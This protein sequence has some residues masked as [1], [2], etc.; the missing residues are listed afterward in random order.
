M[1]VQVKWVESQGSGKFVIKNYLLL[2]ARVFVTPFIA[3]IVMQ[4]VDVLSWFKTC[5]TH[6]HKRSVSVCLCVYIL[7]PQKC[8]INKGLKT[9]KTFVC[10]LWIICVVAWKAHML[11]GKHKNYSARKNHFSFCLLF[12]IA[13]L[14]CVSVCIHAVFYCNVKFS[15]I[16]FVSVDTLNNRQ[17]WKQKITINAPFIQCEATK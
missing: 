6:I 8:L 2:S 9:I 5:M 15:R 4:Y 10:V 16:I 11:Q 12:I 7:L 3:L 14:V 17:L 1:C 13:S